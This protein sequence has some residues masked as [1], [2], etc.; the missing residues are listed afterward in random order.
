MTYQCWIKG[1]RAATGQLVRS[2]SLG[3]HSRLDQAAGAAKN[4]VQSLADYY[5]TTEFHI[6]VEDE[7]LISEFLVTREVVYDVQWVNS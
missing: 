3:T 7:G 1:Q 5:E 6:M 2:L 4:Y